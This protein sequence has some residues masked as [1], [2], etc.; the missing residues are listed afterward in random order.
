MESWTPA[1]QGAEFEFSPILEPLT[2]F[3]DRIL[4]LTGLSNEPAVALPGE[5]AGGHGRIGGAF[6]T[7]VHVKPTE[8][9]GV[10]A[11]VSFDQIAAGQ[12]GQHTQLASLELG[13]EATDLAGPATSVTVVPTSTRSP[14]GTPP[15][16]CPRRTT[17]GRSSNASSATR[18]APIRPS[19]S[20]GSGPNGAFSTR[21]PG[22]RPGCKRGSAAATATSW[23]NTWTRFGTWSGGSRSRKP[24]PAGRRRCWSAPPGS[25]A[26]S[27]RTPS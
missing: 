4:V 14:G 21:S 19:G 3:K 15:L 25:P 12:Y 20:T 6:L 22:K 2:P 10:E 27:K 17:R 9:A 23:S 26:A 8:G 13:L 18:R 1:A 7:G 5:P 11:G 24:K 16:P